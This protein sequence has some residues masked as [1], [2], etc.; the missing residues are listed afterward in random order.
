MGGALTVESKLG[1]GS[2]FA[3]HAAIGAGG[4]HRPAQPTCAHAVAATR[5]D[6][7][8][9]VLAAEDNA[10][11][12]LILKAL[13]APLGVDVTLVGDGAEAV[14]AFRAEAA[15]TWM[16]MDVQMPRMDGLAATTEIRAAGARGLASRRPRS[17]P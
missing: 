6:R 16:L 4:R 9:R 13:L 11:N 7:P 2:T 8:I 10:T 5:S 12:Q 14:E 1:A 3:F 17:S 15:S